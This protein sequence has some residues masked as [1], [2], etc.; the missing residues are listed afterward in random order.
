MTI[1]EHS[2]IAAVRADAHPAAGGLTAA[3][4]VLAAVAVSSCCVLP[5]VLFGLGAGGAWMSTLTAL[6]PYQP[7][8]IA[9]ALALLGYGYWQV[10]RRWRAV[11]DDDQACARPA[12]NRLVISTLVV[13]SALVIVA[14]GFNI[15]VP[16]LL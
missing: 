12:S 9:L 4:S 1:K 13:A 2:R 10:Y 7:Y 6:A 8:L 14:I 11:C 3:G 16:Y 5:L 15:L